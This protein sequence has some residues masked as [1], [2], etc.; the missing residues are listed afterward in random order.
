[1]WTA[2]R[3]PMLKTWMT[4]RNLQQRSI[5]MQTR[6]WTKRFEPGQIKLITVAA[7]AIVTLFT[8]AV[9]SATL[10]STDQSATTNQAR[11][12]MVRPAPNPRFLDWNVLPGDPRT[13]P[14]TSLGEYRFDDWNILPGDTG[15]APV[16]S[17]QTSRFRDWNVLP[18]D[19]AMLVPPAYE[20]G[21]RH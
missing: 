6:T 2:C 4:E 16:T 11:V 7:A 20:R 19:D 1:M 14:V 17:L 13:Y 12:E 18:G 8:G 10:Q 21:A 3:M 5:K 9:L 15:A